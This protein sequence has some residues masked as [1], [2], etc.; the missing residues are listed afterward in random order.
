MWVPG[1]ALA[2]LDS[3]IMPY[4]LTR[5]DVS[6][7]KVRGAEHAEYDAELTSMFSNAVSNLREDLALSD[8]S[9]EASLRLSWDDLAA[10]N[11]C[12]LPDLAITL[13]GVVPGTV[14][15]FTTRTWIDKDTATFYVYQPDDVGDPVSGAYAVATV[16]AS[17]TR[18]I[19]HD[20]LAA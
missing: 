6:H 20:W 1:G 18:R 11:V 8:S 7:A 15:S 16:F 19:A 14:L 4:A 17:D 3:L 2:Q 12:I 5:I 10:F 9:S 13:S